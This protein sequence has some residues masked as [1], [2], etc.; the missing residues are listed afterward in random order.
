MRTFVHLW[1]LAEFFAEWEMFQTDVAEK[2]KTQFYVQLLF[3]R[4]SHRLWD[5][6]KKYCRTRQATDDDII[7]SCVLHAG[8]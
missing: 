1:Y 2:T 8:N 4:K 3:F 5:N 7:G 6:V